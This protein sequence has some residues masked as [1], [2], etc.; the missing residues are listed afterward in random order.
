MPVDALTLAKAFVCAFFAVLFLQSGLDKVT[1][2]K[3]N[4][5]WLTG[6][7][8]NSPFKGMVGLLLSV[9]TL[10]E[11]GAGACSLVGIVGVFVPSMTTFTILGPALSCLALVMLFMGQR[12]AKDYP[13]AASLAT[14]FAV[15]LLG[16]AIV[17]TKSLP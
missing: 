8:A 4:M 10:V 3:G 2:R 7:F 13:G 6:H 15:A 1:D 14:Y 11:L 16:L 17:G 12:I 9:V 5:D